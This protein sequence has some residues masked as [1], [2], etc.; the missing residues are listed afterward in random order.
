[1][2]IIINDGQAIKETN[3]WRGKYAAAGFFYLTWNAGAGRLLVPDSQTHA[4][5]EMA[6][7]RFVVVSAGPWVEQGGRP[8]IELL[9]EDGSDS[10]FCLHLVQEQVDRVL[11]ATDQGGGFIISAWTCS[12]GEQ[13]RWPGKFRQVSSIP[14]LAQW[15]DH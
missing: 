13:G 12:G 7:A 2:F 15:I 4:L 10:P 5:V 9:F 1:M 11:P 14:C 8:A 3:Y 6:S